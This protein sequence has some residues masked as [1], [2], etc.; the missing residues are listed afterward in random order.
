VRVRQF[1]SKTCGCNSSVSVYPR[2]RPSEGC[3]S[4]CV[5]LPHYW[6]NP[7]ITNCTQ[8]S[9]AELAVHPTWILLMENAVSS[10][11][12]RGS[13]TQQ[14]SDSVSVFFLAIVANLSSNGCQGITNFY[15][16]YGKMFSARIN[17]CFGEGLENIYKGLAVWCPETCGCAEQWREG[18]PSNCRQADA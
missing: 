9:D 14:S 17:L 3:P 10:L 7:H 12:T 1:C 2:A 11:F 16:T 13:D 5:H 18:C 15:Q 8:M 4:T 6:Y